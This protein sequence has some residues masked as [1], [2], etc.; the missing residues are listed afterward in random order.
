M[1]DR[2]VF[3]AAVRVA[4]F[5]GRL[6][7][8]PFAGLTAILDAWEARFVARTP[9]TQLAYCMATTFHETAATMQPIRER[10]DIAYFTRLYD[11]AGS[12]PARARKMGNVRRGDG[13]LFRGRGL[14]QL[15]WHANYL[16]ATVRLRE[17]GILGPT[18]SLV[19]S[20]DLALRPDIAVALLFEGMEQGWFTGVDLDETIDAV[21][22]GDEH[23]DFVRARRIIN[24]TDR[25]ETIA[26]H[27]VAFLRALTAAIRAAG[28]ARPLTPA[29][30]PLPARACPTCGAALAA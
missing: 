12:N 3:F 8:E 20:P 11:V 21:T 22:D 24:G 1:I 16:K 23:A 25:A 27:A 15:T 4:L 18:E 9:L 28:P 7:P 2:A 17:L 10:G 5:A 6:A 14:V 29:P 30:A 26:G 19:D 13:A